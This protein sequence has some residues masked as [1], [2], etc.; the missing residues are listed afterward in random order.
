M[1]L[2]SNMTSLVGERCQS[3]LRQGDRNSK[4]KVIDL[5]FEKCFD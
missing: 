5:C 1:N 4:I 2:G 3:L